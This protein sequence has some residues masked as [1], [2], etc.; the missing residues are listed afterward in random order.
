MTETEVAEVSPLHDSWVPSDAYK[1]HA[2]MKKALKL[3][4]ELITNDITLEDALGMGDSLRRMFEGK[5][6]V[7][8]SS[9]VTW[10]VVILLLKDRI[11]QDAV[12]A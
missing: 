9:D 7:H 8:V 2:Q 4:G 6:G 10:G 5:A 12:N 1:A 3:A 11:D